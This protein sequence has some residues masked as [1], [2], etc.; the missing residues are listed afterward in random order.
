MR[1][2]LPNARAEAGAGQEPRGR[3]PDCT[4]AHSRAF[5]AIALLCYPVLLISIPISVPITTSRGGGGGG[6]SDTDT[7]GDTSSVV[8]WRLVQVPGGAE[9]QQPESQLQPKPRA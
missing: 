3:S 6:G 9:I 5:V 7:S 4:A 8:R 1:I 2:L